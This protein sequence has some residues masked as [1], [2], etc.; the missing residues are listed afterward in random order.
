MAI[1]AIADLHLGHAVDKPMDI[2]GSVWDNHP[3]RLREAWE[4]TITEE[5]TV[6]LPGDLS[7]AMT[8]DQARPD[9]DWIGRLPGRKVLIRGN[10]DYWWSGIGKVRRALPPSCWAIQNDAVSIGDWTVCGTRGWLLPDHPHFTE[11]DMHIYQREGERLRLSLQ[12]AAKSNLPIIVAMHFPPL[13]KDGTETIFTKLL[14]EYE[15]DLCVYGH[16]HG[17]SHR[18][19]FEGVRNGIEYRLVSADYLDFQP[20]RLR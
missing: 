16:L 4:R 7:W 20:V 19:A 8:L 9:L 5:D 10:H 15:V 1:F 17:P 6:L 18:F 2:F 13:P 12:Q 3:E 11:Q 14:E